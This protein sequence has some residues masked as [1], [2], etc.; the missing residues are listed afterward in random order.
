VPPQSLSG[1]KPGSPLYGSFCHMLRGFRKP[2]AQ[3]RPKKF[4][5]RFSTVGVKRSFPE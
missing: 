3:I 5:H 1:A 4:T 2:D